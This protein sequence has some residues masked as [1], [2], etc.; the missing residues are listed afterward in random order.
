MR[1]MGLVDRLEAELERGISLGWLPGNG[2][3][4]SERTLAQKEGVSR[5]TAR[6]A[7]VR[8]E[9]RGLIVR[10][11]G[12]RSVA[13]PLEQSLTLENLGVALH[14][15]DSAHPE[16]HVLLAGYFALKRELTVDLLVACCESASHERLAQVDSACY[17]LEEVARHRPER[18]GW[19]A[20]EFEVLR[21]AALAVG[22]PG[23]L[24]LIYSLER[25]LRGMARWVLPHLDSPSIQ[26]WA[27]LAWK[28]LS[29]R[30]ARALRQRLPALLEAS[31]K[32]VLEALA[33]SSQAPQRP[34]PP[35]PQAAQPP[36]PG[37]VASAPEAE[38]TREPAPVHAPRQPPGRALAS[39][40]ET[41]SAQE[42][43][44]FDARRMP[45]GPADATQ[46]EPALAP[47]HAGPLSTR[48]R[49]G[50]RVDTSPPSTDSAGGHPPGALCPNWSDEQTSSS[51][52]PPAGRGPS[53][54]S[55][56]ALE[57]TGPEDWR[58]GTCD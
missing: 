7:L 38:D 49:A 56:V 11:P 39:A 53:P 2:Q 27:R 12:R 14:G 44:P 9:S 16:R 28:A 3:L 51:P 20:H 57:A 25:A 46:P 55:S 41:G 40:S 18:E 36:P 31:D 1:R 6:E 19:A 45:P 4:P 23:Q 10:H 50:V 43:S 17:A 30:D 37:A 52:A 21:R 5:S 15:N 58:A 8:L 13:L 48:E 47:A 24:L 34:E 54:E 32:R 42:P 29:D 26:Q 22:R 33:P 35:S